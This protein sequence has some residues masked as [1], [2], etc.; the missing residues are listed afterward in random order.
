VS[1]AG[2]VMM[3]Y[4]DVEPE[5]YVTLGGKRV[6][7]IPVTDRIGY[8]GATTIHYV[9]PEGQ[10]LGTV[11]EES[12][13]TILPTDAATLERLWKDVNLTRPGDVQR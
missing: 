8:E 12:S 9:S 4:V 11:N 3:R 2:E 7:A 6:R 1:D 5:R 10:Y 13:L